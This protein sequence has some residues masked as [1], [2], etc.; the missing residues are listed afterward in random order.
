MCNKGNKT[1]GVVYFIALFALSI[2]IFYQILITLIFPMRF[3]IVLLLVE[4]SLFF[5]L[6]FKIIWPY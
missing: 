1:P 2:A 6:I 4:I 3:H 5:F